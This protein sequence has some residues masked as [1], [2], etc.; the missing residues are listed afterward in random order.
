MSVVNKM[1]KDLE[2]RQQ[3]HQLSH[4]TPQQ[5]QY[6]GASQRSRSWKW[7]TAL[8][9]MVGG[10]SVYAFQAINTQPAVNLDEPVNRAA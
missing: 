9:L 2:N 6:Q 1:L 7:L 4:I 8:S 5:M 10:V 3:G